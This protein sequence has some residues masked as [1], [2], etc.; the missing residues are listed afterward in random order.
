MLRGGAGGVVPALILVVL[1]SPINCGGSSVSFSLSPWSVPTIRC[2]LPWF[3]DRSCSSAV[4]LLL[5]GREVSSS[6]RSKLPAPLDVGDSFWF[7]LVVEL[8]LGAQWLPLFLVGGVNAI[9]HWR[10]LDGRLIDQLGLY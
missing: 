6:M 10:G 3:V 2:W 1:D 9:I 5:D 8:R 4:E 7:S